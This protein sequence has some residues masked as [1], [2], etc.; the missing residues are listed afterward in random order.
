MRECLNMRLRGSNSSAF[1]EL[2]IYN[3]NPMNDSL[4]GLPES[5]ENCLFWTRDLPIED[6]IGW[7][8]LDDQW[9]VGS[10]KF[11]QLESV[12]LEYFSLYEPMQQSRIFKAWWESWFSSF[13]TKFSVCGSH[14]QISSHPYKSVKWHLPTT[15]LCPINP[16]MWFPQMSLYSSIPR[17]YEPLSLRSHIFIAYVNLIRYKSQ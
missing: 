17:L 1:G 10:P 4:V 11:V 9:P 3:A 14:N 8:N 16:N 12:F 6:D 5:K 7:A 2:T 15:E 13:C